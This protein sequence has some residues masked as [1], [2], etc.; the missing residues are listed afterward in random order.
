M[1]DCVYR[2]EI[3]GGA[4]RARIKLTIGMRHRH[5][6]QMMCGLDVN[7]G[8]IINPDILLLVATMHGSV[9]LSVNLQLSVNSQDWFSPTHFES[10]YAS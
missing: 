9:A 3:Y 7:S 1:N 6:T 5:C 10:N 4:G 8:S 2:A